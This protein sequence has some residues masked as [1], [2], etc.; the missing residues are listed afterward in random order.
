MSASEKGMK[1]VSVQKEI[2][3]INQLLRENTR[4]SK[5]AKIELRSLITQFIQR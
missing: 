5:E 4:Y 1:S 2:D 3:K